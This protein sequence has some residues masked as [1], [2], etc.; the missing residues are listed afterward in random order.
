MHVHQDKHIDL[1]HVCNNISVNLHSKNLQ[2]ENLNLIISL[3]FE[4]NDP[5]YCE[6]VRIPEINVFFRRES[7]YQ[8]QTLLAIQTDHDKTSKMY[9]IVGRQTDT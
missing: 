5:N 3:F 9:R 1:Q 4:N 6:V 7:K 2:T 8:R